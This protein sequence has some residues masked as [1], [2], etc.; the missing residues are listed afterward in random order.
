[1]SAKAAIRR[2][3]PILWRAR[4]RHSPP[5]S[6]QRL[7]NRSRGAPTAGGGRSG[8]GSAC[9]TTAGVPLRRRGLPAHYQ[10]DPG[11]SRPVCWAGRDGFLITSMRRTLERDQTRRKVQRTA[12]DWVHR[13]CAP[14]KQMLPVRLP[15]E[16]TFRKVFSSRGITPQESSNPGSYATFDR[17]TWASPESAQPAHQ[18]R[19]NLPHDPTARSGGR[20]AAATC[21]SRRRPRGG[22][23]RDAHPSGHAPGPADLDQLAPHPCALR[24][25]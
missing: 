9:T 24:R 1:M 23:S 20:I 14:R 7:G 10:H 6:D 19:S 18:L 11:S 2:D 17:P 12:A 22:R 25:R 13:L 15:P 21:P 5:K 4:S 3:L 16:K 8:A